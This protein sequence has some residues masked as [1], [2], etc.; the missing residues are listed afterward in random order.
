MTEIKTC[1]ALKH[2]MEQLIHNNCSR[3]IGFLLLM[4]HHEEFPPECIV[5]PEIQIPL[6]RVKFQAQTFNIQ[7][8]AEHFLCA[9][10]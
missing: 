10:H 5:S 4:K 9:K 8:V 2:L 3:N 6:A 7:L 1:D